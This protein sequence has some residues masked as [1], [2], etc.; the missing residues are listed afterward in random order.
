MGSL[1]EQ[2]GW[3][4][5][6]SKTNFSFL[7]GASHPYHLV[8]RASRCNY[9]S[10]AINDFDGVYGL[11]RSYRSHLCLQ[12]EGDSPLKLNYGAEI[13]LCTDHELPLSLHHT[14]SLIVLNHRGYFNLCRLCSQ[15]HETGK[16]GA[17]LSLTRLLN[18]DLT[19]LVA[20]QPMRGLVRRKTDEK[21][22]S[23]W[24]TLKTVFQDRFFLA[25]SRHQHYSEDLW[26]SKTLAIGKQ[27]ELPFLMSQDAFYHHRNQ[28]PMHD[29]LQAIRTNL[30]LEHASAHMFPNDNRCLQQLG[31]LEHTYKPLP[32]FETALRQSWELNQQCD[33]HL[34]QLRYHYPKEMI[35]AGFTPQKFLDHLTWKGAKHHYGKHLPGKIETQLH[36]EL[37]LIEDLSFAD[38]FLTV[39]DIVNWA[40]NQQILCQGRGSAANSAVCFVLG[41]TSVDPSLFDLLFE[42]FISV[43]RGDPPDI[44]VDFEHERREEVIQYIYRRYGREKAAMVANVITFRKKGALRAVGKALGIP[45]NLMKDASRL[46]RTKAFRAESTEKTTNQVKQQLETRLGQSIPWEKWA[47]LAERLVGFPRHLGIH[48]GG[49]VL[50]DKPIDWLSAQEPA[51]MRGRT[52]IQWSKDDI[53]ALGFFKVD[54][55][56]LG[57]LT[58]IRKCF[59]LIKTQAGPELTLANIP[60]G[61]G[62]TY[63]MIQKA[64]TVGTF[65][66]ESRAQM[67]MLP[68]LKPKNFYDLVIEIAIV[69]PGPIQGKMIHP[70]LRRRYGQEPVTF[71]DPRLESILRRTMGVPIFQEQVMRVAMAVGSFTG[72]E[73]NELRRN[74]GSFSFRGNIDT[75]IPKLISGMKKNRVGD[76]FYSIHCRPHEGLCLLRFPRKPQRQFCPIGLCFLLPQAPLPGCLFYGHSQFPTHGVLPTS[77]PVTVRQT[78]RGGGLTGLCP[79]I[80]L[81]SLTGRETRRRFGHSPWF[82]AHSG[83]LGN[84]Q[85]NE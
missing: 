12:T 37:K 53:E 67:S 24:A 20:I 59:S 34:G 57:M 61:D 31:W 54:I 76:E 3:H 84:R 38:Y 50:S 77:H 41:I 81:G 56:A 63:A 33:F 27:L 80:P 5:W 1:L 42:R 71:P 44:D 28:A 83:T 51:T 79:K 49:F 70:F 40:R 35:P 85:L 65:Q 75:W 74:M 30:N 47:S 66:I 8:K 25:V 4:E 18:A 68:R 45:E 23:Y 58:A 29:L 43:E 64:D 55:L 46:L 36:K 21:L 82:Q 62:A 39:W 78:L 10:L 32:I 13:H 17:H 73:A 72:G 11:A 26:I 60:H 6:L 52:V 48:S 7:A 2:F 19:G 14:L 69:R 15:A 22:K 16:T 9:T